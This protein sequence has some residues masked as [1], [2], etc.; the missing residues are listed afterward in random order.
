MTVEAENLRDRLV[1]N[2]TLMAEDRVQLRSEISGRV[3]GIYFEE[4]TTAEEGELLLKIRD[5]DLQAQRKGKQL[6]ME[7]AEI[8]LRRQQRLLDNQSTTQEAFDE[9]RIRLETLE[10]EL[11]LIDAQ[12]AKTEIRA[13]FTGRV[14]LRQISVG[15]LLDPSTVV[16]SIQDISKLKVDVAVPERFLSRVREGMSLDLRIDGVDKAYRGEVTA[17]DPQIN[18]AT[19]T[20]TL[21]AEIDNSDYQLRPGGF[22]TIELVLSEIEDALLVPATAVIPDLERTTVYVLEDDRAV[23]REIRTGLRTRE[24]V[25]VTEGLQPGDRVIVAGIQDLRDGIEVNVLESAQ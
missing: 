5:D 13:P 18:V 9:A 10:S 15:T 20:I 16:T 23:S 14:G 24:R 11:E 19:R 8:Q 4:G 3:T 1:L 25:Q 22:A 2:A 7:L 6:Q 17:I 12:I 21:R